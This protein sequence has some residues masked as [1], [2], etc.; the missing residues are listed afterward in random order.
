MGRSFT[1]YRAPAASI[2]LDAALEEEEAEVGSQSHL[3]ARGQARRY[4]YYTRVYG[5]GSCA[6]CLYSCMH[7]LPGGGGFSLLTFTH[8]GSRRSY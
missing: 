2:V 5:S 3:G 1:D 7:R 8:G 6:D 4:T